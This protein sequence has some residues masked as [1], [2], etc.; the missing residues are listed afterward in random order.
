[1]KILWIFL[2]GHHKIGLYLVVISMH[3]RVFFLRSRYRIGYIFWGCQNFKYFFGLLVIPN[4]LFWVNGRCWVRAYVCRKKWEYPPWHLRRCMIGPAAKCHLNC[5]LPAG[6]CN[7]NCLGQFRE[8]PWNQTTDVHWGSTLI[9]RVIT[10]RWHHITW[11]W[12]HRNHGYTIT[13]VIAAKETA[14]MY[15]PIPHRPRIAT[16][17]F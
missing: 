13:G 12:C 2:G 5:A 7:R 1:M 3:F 14:N 6:G 17:F 8:I 4:I 15:T 16:I 10:W 11:R 9:T